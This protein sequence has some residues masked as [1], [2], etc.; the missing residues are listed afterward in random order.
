MKV[1]ILI[2][3]HNEA[4]S[5]EKCIL[6]CLNQTYLADEIIVVNDGSTDNSL[7]I[8]KKFKNKIK[9]VNI[10]KATGNKS[11]AQEQGLKYI[12]GDILITTD[13][14]TILDVNFI[15]NIIEEFKDKN[16]M[17]CAGYVKSLQHNWLTASRQIEYLIGQEI[18][19]QA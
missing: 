2:P 8:L 18:H 9:I 15:K 14:D 4:Q 5:I 13:G 16:I 19:K 7:K 6:S 10:L 17:A 11:C 3:C 1:S 12:T